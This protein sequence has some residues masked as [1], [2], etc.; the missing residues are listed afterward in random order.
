MRS[1]AVATASWIFDSRHG[2]MERFL[3]RW[4]FLRALGLIYFSAFFSLFF[5]V[6]GLI[7]PEGV[8]PA[9]NYLTAVAQSMGHWQRIWFA[10]TVLWISSGSAMLMALCWVGITASLLLAIN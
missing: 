8:L 6:K 5:Q 4:L 2:P 10:P 1:T 3:P 9:S 7:G